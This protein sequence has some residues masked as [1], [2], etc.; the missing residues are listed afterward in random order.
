MVPALKPS[1][2]AQRHFDAPRPSQI[3]HPTG[4]R[5]AERSGLGSESCAFKRERPRGDPPAPD[6]KRKPSWAQAEFTGGG[7]P[8]WNPQLDGW[9]PAQLR[10]SNRHEEPEPFEA[11]RLELGALFGEGR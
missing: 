10:I 1:A 6:R 8:P 7:S 2:R 4:A 11:L 9:E 5:P 3:E